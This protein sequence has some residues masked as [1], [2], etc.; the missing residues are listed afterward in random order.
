MCSRRTV[1]HAHAWSTKIKVCWL[2]VCKYMCATRTTLTRSYADN[3]LMFECL[4]FWSDYCWYLPICA[5][6]QVVTTTFQHGFMLFI[7]E[8]LMCIELE[9]EKN[10]PPPRSYPLFSAFLLLPCEYLMECF[11]LLSKRNIK[12]R[13][14]WANEKPQQIKKLFT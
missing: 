10:S 6:L 3:L 7:D 11:Q 1:E 2:M 4:H 9:Q 8:L 12:I 5:L 14:I 13:R